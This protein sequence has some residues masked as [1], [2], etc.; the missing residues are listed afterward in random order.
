[1]KKILLI[2]FL[3]Y[4]SKSF[5][6]SLVELKGCYKTLEI[7][8]TTPSQGPILGRNQTRSEEFTGGTYTDLKNKKPI[9]INVFTFFTGFEAPYYSY[10]PFV[11]FKDFAD[12]VIEEK[13]YLYYEVDTDVYME[14]NYKRI[15]VDHYVNAEFFRDQGIVT[16]RINFVSKIRNINRTIDFKL[17]IQDCIEYANE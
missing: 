2:A 11:F 14:S 13:D 5:A 6:L 16:G 3:L 9:D 12:K 10:A 15:K 7:N 1:M 17:G 8:G 4:C